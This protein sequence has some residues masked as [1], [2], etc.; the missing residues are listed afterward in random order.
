MGDVLEAIDSLSE[1]WVYILNNPIFAIKLLVVGVMIGYA[2]FRLILGYK[3]II[4]ENKIAELEKLIASES[5]DA[6]ERQR[7]LELLS[8]ASSIVSRFRADGSPGWF[9]DYLEVQPEYYELKPLLKKSYG[10]GTLISRTLSF[11]DVSAV[12]KQFIDELAAIREAWGFS[13]TL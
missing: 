8:R 4:Q 6:L 10:S 1:D 13:H 7:K 5:P 11:S 3:N 12:E 9:G 2:S